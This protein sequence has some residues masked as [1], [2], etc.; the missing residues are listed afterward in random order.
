FRW[1]GEQGLRVP[2]IPREI[3][4]AAHT[5]GLIS[6]AGLWEQIKDYRDETLH[7]Y[8]ESKAIGVSAFVRAKA[9]GAFD[10][11]A[12]NLQAYK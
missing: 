10:A 8:N 5:A 1:L 11:L 4:K 2:E 9:A 7:T 6:D 12:A 3:I